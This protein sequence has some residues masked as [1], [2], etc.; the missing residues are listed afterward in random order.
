MP[1][2]RDHTGIG[3]PATESPPTPMVGPV[4]TTDRLTLRPNRLDD[5]E[6]YADLMAS[7]RS[8][9][10]GGPFDR[11]RAWMLFAS[12]VVQWQFYGH[13]GM[14]VVL[15]RSG[16]CVGQVA[17]NCLPGFP[18]RELGW[19]VYAD[20]EGRGYMT[21][22][23]H[24]LKAYA[25]EILHWPTLVSYISRDNV[26]SIALARRLGGWLD[27]EAESPKTYDLVF[28]YRPT[29]PLP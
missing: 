4:L 21:E 8:V 28:R 13:G 2:D 9:Y 27:T 16:T 11:Q 25:F 6:A 15:T 19:M 3:C 29:E 17:L 14:A 10:I 26:R 20:H 12:D 1:A 22:A 7:E 18:E 23:A 5:F 24:C